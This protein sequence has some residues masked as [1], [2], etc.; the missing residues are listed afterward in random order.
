MGGHESNTPDVLAITQ[1]MLEGMDEPSTPESGRITS[2]NVDR[3][4]WTWVRTE[5]SRRKSL[6]LKA[7]NQDLVQ[8][9][10]RFDYQDRRGLSQSLAIMRVRVQRHGIAKVNFRL[11]PQWEEQV[12]AEV[13]TLN[14]EGGKASLISVL[15]VRMLAWAIANG[16][17]P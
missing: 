6:G 10:A 8:E 2:L 4:L 12:H 3:K 16:F 5:A 17:Q 14:A 1:L 13:K 9:G 11:D 15:S 7:R